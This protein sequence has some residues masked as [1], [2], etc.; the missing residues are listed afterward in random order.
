MFTTFSRPFWQPDATGQAAGDLTFA[1]QGLDWEMV[2]RFRALVDPN[3]ARLRDHVRLCLVAA[4]SVLLSQLLERFP[5]RDG[6]LEVVG[7]LVLATQDAQNYV[8]GDQ[9]AE[10]QIVGSA[11]TA[12]RWR[13]PEVLFARAS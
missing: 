8:P 1:V 3:L 7:Y 4:E 9:F 11:G 6:I 10:V 12:E 5:P 2:N 13:V